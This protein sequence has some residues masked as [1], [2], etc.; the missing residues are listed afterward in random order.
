MRSHL[1]KIGGYENIFP[2]PLFL[3]EELGD[4]RFY[5]QFV[6]NIQEI[7]L[8]ELAILRVIMQP[9]LRKPNPQEIA[10]KNVFHLLL[11]E[12][13]ELYR[14]IPVIPSETKPLAKHPPSI[15]SRDI[16]LFNSGTFGDTEALAWLRANRSE[17]PLAVERFEKRSDAI[18]FV[19]KLYDL[20]AKKVDVRMIFGEKWRIES[21]GGSY[22]TSLEITLPKDYARRK[23]IID[24]IESDLRQHGFMDFDQ[25]LS[26]TYGE[27]FFLSWVRSSG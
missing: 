24:L 22:A 7:T 20:G 13:Q 4:D 2:N 19:T 17:T 21:T 3:L 15:D 25:S 14:Q 9:I 23:K 8:D 10:Y 18:D 27:T 26:D 16:D 1:E 6:Q 12:P 5:L 11:D